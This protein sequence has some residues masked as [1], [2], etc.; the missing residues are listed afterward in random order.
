MRGCD[1]INGV[2]PDELLLEVFRHLETKSCR[3]ACS[4]VCK[5]W[6]SLERLGRE[7]IRIAA[8]ASPEDLIKAL[9]GSFPNIRCVFVDESIYVPQPVEQRKK[10]RTGRHALSRGRSHQSVSEDDG[11]YGMGTSCL[12]DSGLIAVGESFAK[13]EKL[14]L[15]WCSSIRDVGLQSFA[16]KCSTLKSL[17]LQGSYIGDQGLASV[18]ECCKFLQDL[19][20][21]FCEGLTDTGLVQLVLGC[22]MTLKSL[23]IAACAKITDISLEIVGSHCR[24]LESLS[25]DS[26]FIHNIGL[27]AVAKGCSRLK[28]LKLQCLN[29]T[30]EA[31]QAVGV[32]CL[33]LEVLALN[34]FQRFTDRSLYAIGKG[35]KKLKTLM[36]TDCY[37]LSNKG[38]DCIAV[39]CS[40]LMHVEVNGCHNI[41]TDGL[42]SIGKFCTR[43]SE[44]AL[45]YCQ[46]IGS[47][48]LSEIG[49]G[50]QFLQAVHLVD[51]SAVGDDSISSI[52]KGCK[53]LRKLHIRRCYEVFFSFYTPLFQHISSHIKI[54]DALY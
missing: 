1:R 22:G 20:L 21:R 52:A 5:R 36:L 16:N 27:L 39:G 28:I 35:C 42:K 10:R 15:V 4:L 48:A 46:R 38:L 37:F 24:S 3:D 2:L 53:N 26:E 13:L 6:L 40:E 41:G 18:G 43:L 23:G 9:S 7:T 29:I 14:S 31:L 12:S 11:N 32:S 25:L 19:N 45:L 8:S 49:K 54:Y 34:G 30:D 47:D 51:C 17:D 50:C 33:S 44:L